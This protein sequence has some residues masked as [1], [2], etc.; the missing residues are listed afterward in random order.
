MTAK[1]TKPREGCGKDQPRRPASEPWCR[2]SAVTTNGETSSSA[3]VRRTPDCT[4]SLR[5]ELTVSSAE[6]GPEA[7]TEP[8]AAQRL[9][10]EGAQRGQEG[11]T[12][13]RRQAWAGNGGGHPC[14]AHGTKRA[15]LRP[16]C[17][18]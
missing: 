14:P 3:G 1:A 5:R 4:N 8:A 2:N 11:E 13:G 15:I 6:F 18:D 16:T 10:E 9:A 12:A 17:R 7:R